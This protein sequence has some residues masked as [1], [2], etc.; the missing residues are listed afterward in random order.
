M[1]IMRTN[2][3][4]FIAKVLVLCM[5]VGL[6]PTVALAEGAT[7]EKPSSG[8]YYQID[9]DATTNG[10]VTA[11]YTIGSDSHPYTIC[12][13]TTSKQTYYIGTDTAGGAVKVQVKLTPD[14]DYEIDSSAS[15]YQIGSASQVK[16]SSAETTITIPGNADSGTVLKIHAEFK[17][18]S[19]TPPSGGS[20]GGGGAADNVVVEKP[21]TGGGDT[22][23]VVD[24]KPTT[25]GTTSSATI[26][27]KKMN[28]AVQSALD[29]SSKNGTDP[30][31]VVKVETPDTATGMNVT[32]PSAPLEKL[33]TDKDATLI[34]T[35]GVAE[36]TFDRTAIAAIAE[37]AG[38]TLTISVTPAAQSS[39]SA[40]QKEVVGTAPVFD[41]SITSNGKAITKFGNGVLAVTLPYTLAQGQSSSD[42]VVYY[43]SDAAVLEA[44]PTS[45]KSGK[46]TFT[47]THLSKYVIGDT[48]MGPI[49]FTDVP[50]D[51]FYADAVEWAVSNGITEGVGNNQFAPNN[52]CTR[53]QI[54]TFLWRAAG[55]PE[56]T[57]TANPFTDVD[58]RAF[59][60][61]AVLWA[62]EKGITVGTS[63]TTFAPN[64]TCT[65]AEA[66]TFLYRYAGTP[67]A[68]GS[69][70]S[71]VPAN[72]FYANAVA[73]A[74]ANGITNGVGNDQFAPQAT[75]TRAQIV[76][77]LYRDLAK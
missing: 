72:A 15:Y 31:V 40:A 13:D 16:I 3:K 24:V 20:G 77:F 30:V 14:T 37:E 55:S 61:K 25:S 12:S 53:S 23:V 35:S 62:V 29:T 66:V 47:T 45:Y 49:T 42:V 71:D 44:C 41:L 39:L 64:G 70:F 11:T 2:I 63:A 10:K 18:K 48:S 65:R 7:T 5:I 9:V 50:A 21:S 4:G 38:S 43:L 58:T 57:S 68:S 59:Y 52:S 76:T 75:C 46:V 67:A 8:T 54:V 33:G 19:S 22:T 26:P 74:V 27:D 73:W 17:V 32:L 34:V 28:E 36:L 69:S 6:L 60:G 56:P 51:A 1:T